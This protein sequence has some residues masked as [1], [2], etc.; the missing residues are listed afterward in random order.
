[1]GKRRNEMPHKDRYADDD[2]DDDC[3]IEESE[4]QVFKQDIFTLGV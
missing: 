3:E 2:D 4:Q 1:M